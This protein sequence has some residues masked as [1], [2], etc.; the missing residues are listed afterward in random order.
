MCTHM[1]TLNACMHSRTQ[2]QHAH[3][4][5][6]S[7]LSHLTWSPNFQGQFIVVVAY[8]GDITKDGTIIAD[9]TCVAK[10][11]L[12]CSYHLCPQLGALGVATW[13]W[14]H[15]WGDCKCMVSA[16]KPYRVCEWKLCEVHF[17]PYFLT[18]SLAIMST[19]MHACR[20]THAHTQNFIFNICWAAHKESTIMNKQKKSES[21]GPSQVK[22]P[23]ANETF[24]WKEFSMKATS[25]CSSHQDHHTGNN[26]TQILEVSK[27]K[28]V[29]QGNMISPMIQSSSYVVLP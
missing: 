7:I 28:G 4:A 11:I 26:P 12:R 1:H 6:Q 5:S 27:C 13:F 10:V 19:H 15:R 18:E 17:Y 14:T 22:Q 20:H 21:C 25:F 9:V 3:F 16:V 2:T 8:E 29:R 24:L 23:M